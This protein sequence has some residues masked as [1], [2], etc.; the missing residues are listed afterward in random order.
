MKRLLGRDKS[1]HCDHVGILGW[2]AGSHIRQGF[3]H[4]DHLDH[5]LKLSGT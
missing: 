4:C 3:D 1:D 2:S 5:L